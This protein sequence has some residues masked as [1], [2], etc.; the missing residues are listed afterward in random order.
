MKILHV[1]DHAGLGGAQV[2]LRG[3]LSFDS[4]ELEQH[5][6]VLRSTDSPEGSRSAC[7]QDRSR[8]RFS[9]LP[10]VRLARLCLRGR[11]D[12]LHAHLFR[13]KVFCWAIKRVALPS[14]TL[15]FHEHGSVEHAP[16]YRRFLRIAKKDVDGFIFVSETVRSEVSAVVGAARISG[17]VL[18]NFITT[19]HLTPGLSRSVFSERFSLPEN[20]FLIGFLGRIV[21]RKGWRDFISLAKRLEVREP[22][23]FF[24]IAGDGQDRQK[25]VQACERVTNCKAIG[26]IGL[27]GSFIRALDCI[28]VPSHYEPMG[29]VQLEAQYGGT[30]V[31]AYDVPGLNETVEHDRNALLAPVGDVE[32]LSD[33]LLRLV[34]DRTLQDRLRHGGSNN[35]KLFRVESYMAKL[36][37]FYRSLVK[38]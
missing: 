35:A 18:Y 24:V 27:V 4:P 20:R 36:A 34:S 16:L 21:E 5:C 15:I 32:A 11:F 37:G 12:I 28:V 6:Y 38:S 8:S 3:I 14:T 19:Q 33:Q 22:R 9:L 31:I 26:S 25:V 7:I 23:A 17:T 13:S 30:P 10:F 2:V 1:I 29:L